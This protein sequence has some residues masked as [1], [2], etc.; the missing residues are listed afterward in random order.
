MTK[1]ILTLTFLL[2]T[3]RFTGFA[4]D[5]TPNS[6]GQA[7]CESDLITVV[8]VIDKE[9]KWIK[10]KWKVNFSTPPPDTI[11][12]KTDIDGKSNNDYNYCI[13]ITVYILEVNHLI[14]GINNKSSY[15]IYTNENSDCSK[16]LE[17]DQEYLCYLKKQPKTRY[18]WS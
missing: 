15:L 18:L 1:Q 5:C 7:T 16:T 17:L 11:Q 12:C 13:P 9:T 10:Q 8:K 3:I 2:L 4:C 14:T 6:I